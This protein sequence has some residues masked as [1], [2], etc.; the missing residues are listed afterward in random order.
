MDSI[1]CRLFLSAHEVELL[2]LLAVG[3]SD[4]ECR[5]AGEPVGL[6]SVMRG[7]EWVQLSIGDTRTLERLSQ[8]PAELEPADRAAVSLL[9][10]SLG[11]TLCRYANGLA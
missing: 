7:D 9:R 6:L 8:T 3:H 2:R 10:A 5:A 1:V 4:P 11:E